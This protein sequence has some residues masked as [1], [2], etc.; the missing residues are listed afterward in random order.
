MKFRNNGIE[1]GVGSLATQN[2]LLN[3][4]RRNNRY[5]KVT[6]EKSEHKFA[7]SKSI[8]PQVKELPKL[9]KF[10]NQLH[11]TYLLTQYAAHPLKPS[12]HG[13]N[14]ILKKLL[15]HGFVTQIDPI[16]SGSG[17]ETFGDTYL[18]TKLAIEFVNATLS[19]PLKQPIDERPYTA[20]KRNEK[21]S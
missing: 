4:H 2:F 7:T 11:I 17:A 9:W 20:R 21:P 16:K 14:V 12:K 13:S 8:G 15:K 10:A 19:N 6:G 18:P 1:G 3:M 5:S